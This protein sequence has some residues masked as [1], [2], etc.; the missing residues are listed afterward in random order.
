MRNKGKAKGS[1]D[2]DQERMSLPTFASCDLLKMG[3]NLIEKQPKI[4]QRTCEKKL[5]NESRG[6]YKRNTTTT[7]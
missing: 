2:Q 6:S 4:N 3:Y 5:V 7:T 1:S